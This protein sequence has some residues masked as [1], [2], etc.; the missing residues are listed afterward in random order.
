MRKV[1][2]TLALLL[3]FC[4]LAS[5]VSV[6]AFAENNVG[7]TDSSAAL[8][9][10]TDA[11]VENDA[12][13]VVENDADTVV[14]DEKNADVENETDGDLADTQDT[15]IANVAETQSSDGQDEDNTMSTKADD[16][17]RYSIVMVDCGRKYF[18]VD[19]LKSI[20]DSASNAGMYYVMLGIGNDGMRFLL[21]DMSL[22]VNG[23][24]YTSDDV[25]N[26]IHRGNENYSNFDTDELTETDMNAIMSY[27]GTKGVEIIPLINS[28]GHMDA[29]L[30]AMGEL[31]LPNVAY[32]LNGQSS[33]RTIDVTNSTAT[34]FTQ[35]LLKKYIAYFA[36]QGCTLFNMGADEYGNDI[37]GTPHFSDLIRGDG[38]DDYITY[39][40]A[41]AGMIETAGMT[42]M[43]FNDGIY[44]NNSVGYGTINTN[45]LV[46]Y[47]SNGW[48]GYNLATA[49]Y[50]KEQGFKLINTNGDY[51]WIVGGNQITASKAAQFDKTS[52]PKQG[53]NEIISDPTGSMFCI[54]S[55]SPQ[56]Q[57]DSSVASSVSAVISAF[58]NTLPETTQS[59]AH[60][61]VAN[62]IGAPD[63]GNLTVEETVILS[64]SNSKS[65]VWTS[66]DEKVVTLAAAT[67]SDI[68][69]LS[70]EVNADRVKATAVGTGTATI[71]AVV[72]QKTYTTEVTVANAE[73]ENQETISLEI[74]ETDSRVQPGVNNQN[75]TDTSKHDANVAN[76]TVVGTDAKPVSYN[77]SKASSV[78][79]NSLCDND[80]TEWQETNYYYKAN[81]G[82]YYPLYVKRSSEEQGHIL[83]WTKCT[84]TFGYAETD[85]DINECGTTDGSLMNPNPT[86]SIPIYTRTEIRGTDASTTINFKGVTPGTTYYKV[87]DITYKIVVNPIVKSEN[88]TVIVGVRDTIHVD[89][90]EGGSVEYQVTNGQNLITVDNSGNVTVG[91]MVGQAT[92]VATVKTSSGAVYGTYTYNYTIENEDLSQVEPLKIEYWITNA[93]VTPDAKEG[94][95]VKNGSGTRTDGTS[96]T[97]NY[98]EIT[99]A[100]VNTE[101]GV[102]LSSL[103]SGTGTGNANPVVLWKGRIL[104]GNK[105][106]N[107]GGCDYTLTVDNAVDFKYIRYYNGEWKYSNDGTTWTNIPSGAQIVAYYLQKTTVTQA[108]DILVKDWGYVKGQSSVDR[109]FGWGSSWALSFAVVYD[110]GME[111][112]ES[113]LINT[114]TFYNGDLGRNVGYITFDNTD[115]YEVYKVTATY[116]IRSGSSL[117]NMS[118]NYNLSGNTTETTVWE[119][120][121]SETAYVNG[122]EHNC[123]VWDN[124]N[125]AILIRIYVREKVKTDTLKIVYKLTDGTEFYDLNVNAKEGTNFAG[126]VTDGKLV[127]DTIENSVGNTQTITTN[128][129]DT[130]NLPNMP[131]KYKSGNY[132]YQNA[133][134]SED[135]KTLYLIYEGTNTKTFVYD[136]GL[137]ME[138]QASD[139]VDNPG[140]VTSMSVSDLNKCSA[141]ANGKS[142]IAT[143][144]NATVTT[145]SFTAIVNFNSETINYD[146][147]LVPATTVYYEEGFAD[148]SANWTGASSGSSKQNTAAL[149]EDTNNYGYDSIYTDVAAASNGTQAT[150]ITKNDTATFDF[151]GTGVDIFA[152]TTTSTGYLTI[153]ITDSSSKVVNL[154]IVNTKMAGDYK[155]DVESGYNVPVFSITDLAHGTYTVK[156]THSMDNTEVNVDGFRVYNT[157][158]DSSIYKADS[159]DN[160]SFLEVRDLQFGTID[161]S[162]YGVDG[163]TVSAVGEQVYEDLTKDGTVVEAL[164]SASGQ[165]GTANQKDL[166]EKGPKNEVYLAKNSALTL[167][168][169]TNREV[170]LGL[171]GVNG[172]TA[173]SVN[174][175]DSVKVSTVDMFYTIQ[176]KSG[177][178]ERATETT[179]TI[180]NT[181]DSVLS[182]TKLKV[183]DDPNALQEITA[184]SVTSALYTWGFK[185][186]VPTAD[187]TANINLVDYTGAIIADTSLIMNGKE[188]TEAEFSAEAIKDAA[189]SV[190]AEDYAIVNESKIV[191][192]TVKYGENTDVTVQVGK[193]AHLQ[194][195][196]KKLFGKTVGTATL[197]GIQISAGDKY[198]FSASDIVA[199]APDGYWTIKLLGSKVKYGSTGKLTVQVL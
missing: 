25:K 10:N 15:E 82:N 119:E 148:F 177:S 147:Y 166:L 140:E 11:D 75:N 127:K 71:T 107:T 91:S 116:G 17:Y 175:G 123:C 128:L 121:K 186:P 37:N 190:L 87:G 84:W 171:K 114:S 96:Y 72:G 49:G 178:N 89:V 109:W 93:Q 193:V 9:N 130:V 69:A 42:P 101:N 172:S 149:G 8:A 126:Y 131:A 146:V 161:V 20:I 76:V 122:A 66:S 56:A 159:E 137:P 118:V 99:A 142:I 187:A 164:I 191:N 30:D 63:N 173:Y 135:N 100:S 57:T 106:D 103:I 45:I 133:A 29:I 70:T 155:A 151:T 141:S 184:D 188:G 144:A 156:I 132:K 43:A 39:L 129:Q 64:L 46:C 58:G 34:A 13:T 125:S 102:P 85:N 199:A 95:T 198:S 3:T 182:V 162:N 150:S 136:F 48:S 169:T 111:P 165:V 61:D 2:K 176:A 180:K 134:L 92:V 79:C 53:G 52:F 124:S 153:K 33:E 19:S 23:K 112:S 47:W 1:K 78:K 189:A 194:V 152:N 113:N 54:W 32:S 104:T 98:S 143:V 163:R 197:T 24:S 62:I 40:N 77:Y 158:S 97:Y 81:D 4:M 86:L 110:T 21:D 138:I 74:G 170:Q 154:A 185:D 51:Y 183:C 65:A 192:Q 67:E 6:T 157:R 38:Y 145:A 80:T 35:A 174:E 68:S 12:D 94:V 59:A 117:S 196:Y 26:A 41:V 22:T 55:D 44:Y 108:V 50:L 27:A 16:A 160:P 83:T 5:C 115:D 7:T 90:P 88:K 195:T 168:F 179:V 167:K 36:E 28:P 18:S 105:Q 139:L 73:E 14:E 181:G 60:V 120:G 31:G